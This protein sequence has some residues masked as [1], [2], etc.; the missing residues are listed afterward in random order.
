MAKKVFRSLPDMSK[1]RNRVD[2]PSLHR[3]EIIVPE[4]VRKFAKGRKYWISTFGCQ[5]NV[6]D[7]EIMAGYL[8]KAGFTPAANEAEADFAIINTCAVRENAEEKVYGEIG[9]FKANRQKD[10]NFILC[11]C[12]CMMQDR[13]SV[14]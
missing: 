8:E 13:K 11:L 7:Q 5:A 3:D 4:V 10:P 14:V 6:R 9:K 12:G 2:A 1:A